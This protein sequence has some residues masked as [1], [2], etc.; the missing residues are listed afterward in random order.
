MVELFKANWEEIKYSKIKPRKQKDKGSYHNSS[1]KNNYLELLTKGWNTKI[2][3]LEG[4]A[5]H[6]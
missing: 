2:R 5:I 6:A 1:D 3:D 4:K